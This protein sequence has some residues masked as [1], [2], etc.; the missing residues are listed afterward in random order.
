MAAL[1]VSLCVLSSLGAA[2]ATSRPPRGLS[3]NQ[4]RAL[5]LVGAMSILSVPNAIVGGVMRGDHRFFDYSALGNQI[6]L[7]APKDSTATTT[8]APNFD[9]GPAALEKSF[10]SSWFGNERNESTGSDEVAAH[11]PPGCPRRTA[12]RL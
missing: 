10:A 7:V 4:V 3:Y 8:I 6:V 12:D 9:L 2:A 5:M 11:P 1:V